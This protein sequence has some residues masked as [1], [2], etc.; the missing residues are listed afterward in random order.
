MDPLTWQT[1]WVAGRRAGPHTWCPRPYAN[2][3]SALPAWNPIQELSQLEQIGRRVCGGAGG[4]EP[5]DKKSWELIKCQ[6]K[7]RNKTIPSKTVSQRK[8][9]NSTNKPWFRTPQ[10][11]PHDTHA[12]MKANHTCHTDGA[13]HLHWQKK[14]LTLAFK[15]GTR[16]G[17]PWLSQL[18]LSYSTE[19]NFRC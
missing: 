1:A 4:Q 16:L 11:L 6:T 5:K 8:A 14:V 15:R 9:Q 7:Q 13:Q 3:S 19:N 10:R 18:Q 2:R 17:T 12:N